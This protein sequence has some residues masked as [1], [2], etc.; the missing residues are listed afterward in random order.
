[1]ADVQEDEEVLRV[2]A[3]VNKHGIKKIDSLHI[4]CAIRAGADGFL[5]TDDSIL[6]KATLIQDVQITD[7]IGFIKG[8]AV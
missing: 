8:I 4:A 2:A 6:K 1:M 3:A 5:T 7:P